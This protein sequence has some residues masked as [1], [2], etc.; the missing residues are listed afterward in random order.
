MTT[1]LHLSAL[2][3]IVL[4]ILRRPEVTG[5]LMELAGDAANPDRGV[6]RSGL[7]IRGFSDPHLAR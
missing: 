3:L 4:R 2:T 7:G 5:R 1:P 6:L